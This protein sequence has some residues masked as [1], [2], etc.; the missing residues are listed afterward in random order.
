MWKMSL[1]EKSE[2]CVMK[3]EGYAMRESEGCVKQKKG[4]CKVVSEGVEMHGC[5][6]VLVSEDHV[7]GY[8]VAWLNK[9]QEV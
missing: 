4:F 5:S 8:H 6:L 2:C 9:L 3:S 1:V 7:I